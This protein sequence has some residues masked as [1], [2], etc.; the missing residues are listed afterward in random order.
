MIYEKNNTNPVLNL[1]LLK[2]KRYVGLT[3]VPVVASFSF[4]TLL[5][6][7]PSYLTGVIQFSS[8]YSGIVMI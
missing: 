6:Y 7:Y 5:T 2:N 8:S 3:L 1:K 4:V